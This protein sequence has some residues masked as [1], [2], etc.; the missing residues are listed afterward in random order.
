MIRNSCWMMVWKALDQA[1]WLWRMTANPGVTMIGV[2]DGEVMMMR[3]EGLGTGIAITTVGG[4]GRVQVQEAIV[5]SGVIGIGIGIMGTGAGVRTGGAMEI[6][7]H[8]E[9]GNRVGKGGA[10]GRG[11]TVENGCDVRGVRIIDRGIAVGTGDTAGKGRGES[12]ARIPD[13]EKGGVG[14]GSEWDS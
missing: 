10:A 14:M 13:R 2:T 1:A 6:E 12:E 3:T 7:S 5:T 9:F 4:I 8:R 11:V